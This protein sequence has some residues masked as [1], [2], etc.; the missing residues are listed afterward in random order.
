MTDRPA[1]FPTMLELAQRYR[2]DLVQ[3]AA[4]PAEWKRCCPFHGEQT[5][6]FYVDSG[7]QTFR[8]FGCGAQGDRIAFVARME[9]LAFPDAVLL[10]HALAQGVAAPPP[11]AAP[12]R[13]IQGHPPAARLHG[14]ATDLRAVIDE[15]VIERDDL[16]E[17]AFR[18]DRIARELEVKS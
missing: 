2:L 8:C 3:I 7:A 15:A 12:A 16:R 17:L 10:L 11:S 9:G 14:V 18:I 13:V 6:S 1:K 4:R 5:P